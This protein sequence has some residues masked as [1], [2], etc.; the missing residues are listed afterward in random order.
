MPECALPLRNDMRLGYQRCLTESLRRTEGAS[1]G[2][3]YA[4]EQRKRDNKPTAKGRSFQVDKA[5]YENRY[6]SASHSGPSKERSRVLGAGRALIRNYVLSVDLGM[7][8]K[9]TF[10][11]E[12]W[13][14]PT[15]T[16][17]S[18]AMPARFVHQLH[19]VAHATP[20][21]CEAPRNMHQNGEHTR[22]TMDVRVTVAERTATA[23]S[24]G[25]KEPEYDVPQMLTAI[26]T[27]F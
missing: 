20:K 4:P 16:F 24:C 6:L 17:A 15:Q 3:E 25:A 9:L 26:V 7:S 8:D 21:I 14:R 1:S 11:S 13:A 2:V 23:S 12:L 5:T 10:L 19:Y 22:D 18:Q 27:T